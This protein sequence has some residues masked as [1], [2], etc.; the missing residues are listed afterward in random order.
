MNNWLSLLPCRHQLTIQVKWNKHKIF[1]RRLKWYINWSDN[2]YKLVKERS[3]INSTF[4]LDNLRIKL[5]HYIK[6]NEWIKN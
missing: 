2:T 6:Q 5:I 3:D 4:N 1:K